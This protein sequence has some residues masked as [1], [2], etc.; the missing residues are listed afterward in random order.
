MRNLFD[1][2]PKSSRKELYDR[3]KELEFL[4]K[5]VDRP[6]VAVLGVRRI[7]KTSLLKAFLEPYR[8]IDV[9]MRGGCHFGRAL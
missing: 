9:D 6:L 4:D 2:R 1:P 8:G 7:G 3:E 5:N